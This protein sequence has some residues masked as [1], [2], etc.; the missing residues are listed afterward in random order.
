[1]STQSVPP[2][3][4][5][6]RTSAAAAGAL[7]LWRTRNG[8]VVLVA[9]AITVLAFAAPHAARAADGTALTKTA[10]APAPRASSHW[11]VL[12][13]SQQE[14]LAP[15]GPHWDSLSDAQRRKWLAL[16]RNFNRIGP[17]EQAKLHARM[18]D[19]A[20]LSPRQRALAR[21]NYAEVRSLAPADQRKAEWEAYMAL[22]PEE[23]QKLAESAGG[24]RIGAAPAARPVSNDKLVPV[25]ATAFQQPHGGPRIQITPSPGPEA[26]N[27]VPVGDGSQGEPAAG[28]SPRRNTAEPTATAP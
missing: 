24:H 12:T 3:P 5:H 11:N 7:P 14:A 16:S 26:A 19:W 8:A 28:L 6:P 2:L 22:S 13:R 23:R 27:V 9:A 18:T 21:L 10:A 4:R 15:L 20:A 1:M 25:P 17:A